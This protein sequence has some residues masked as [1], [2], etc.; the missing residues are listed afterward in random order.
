MKKKLFSAALA[1]AL[2]L[3]LLSGCA[4]R[5]AETPDPS[6]SAPQNT[7]VSPS[8]EPTASEK[9]PVPAE[10]AAL[11]T[12]S[13]YKEVLPYLGFDSAIYAAGGMARDEEAAAEAP[14]ASPSAAPNEMGGL[15]GGEGDYS[16]TN[17]QVE[18]IDEADVVKTD[19]EY[20]YTLQGGRALIITRADGADTAMVSRTQLTKSDTGEN[21]TGYRY[22]YEY[23]DNMYIV[24]DRVVV[25]KNVYDYGQ[26]NDEYYD[27]NYITADIYDVSDPSSPALVVS[28]GQDGYLSDSRL[29]GNYLYLVS[30]YYV[31]DYDEDRPSTYIPRLYTNG[32]ESVLPADCIF[33]PGGVSETWT[34]V[35]GIDLLA[36]ETVSTATALCRADTVYMKGGSIYIVNS[37]WTTDE[38]QPRT[39]DQY[40]VVDYNQYAQTRILRFAAEDGKVSADGTGALPGSLLNQFSIDEKD[41]YLRVVTTSASSSYSVYTDKKYDFVNYQWH[42]DYESA[43]GLYVLDGD[44][45]VVGQIDG[46]GEDERVYSARFD[47]DIGYFVT[48]RETDPLFAVDLSDPTAPKLLSALKIPGFSEYLHVY[49][50]GLLFGLGMAA[51]DEGRTECLKLSMFDT[52]D[53]ADVKEAATYRLEDVWYSPALYDHHACFISVEKNLIGFAAEDEYLFFTYEN[54]AFRQ[55][56]SVSL[57]EGYWDYNS[58]GL[59]IGDYLYVCSDGAITVLNLSDFSTVKTV[60]LETAEP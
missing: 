51:D 19:G 20:I 9:P 57:G 17:V 12:V 23:A 43:S 33:I 18:G 55:L 11:M 10:P 46:L 30:S 31:Y 29:A 32:E 26:K 34:V 3:G 4:E 27:N 38:S 8:P 21:D 52:S 47:G 6:P 39:E 56:A 28:L 25:L 13:D 45:K 48:F 50:D 24:G 16:G 59:Y 37:E 53:K 60:M 15:G 41:G 36:G 49:G 2:L 1:A 42:D 35:S 5:Q 44:L 58:R 22:Y 7:T 40:E 54:G 14:M